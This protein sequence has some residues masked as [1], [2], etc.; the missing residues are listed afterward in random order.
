MSP[1]RSAGRLSDHEIADGITAPAEYLLN[2]VARSEELGTRD[3]H[4]SRKPARVAGRLRPLIGFGRADDPSTP[5]ATDVLSNVHRARVWP[6][7]AFCGG[8]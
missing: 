4:L 1:R 7:N 3:R 8:S 5:S 2:T 6:P